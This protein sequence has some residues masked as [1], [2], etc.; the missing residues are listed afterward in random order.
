MRPSF[1][2]SD[3]YP[4]GL[5]RDASWPALQGV[6]RWLVALPYP[7]GGAHTNP[8]ATGMADKRVALVNNKRVLKKKAAEGKKPADD[9]DGKKPV[10]DEDERK[11]GDEADDDDDVFAVGT[12]FVGGDGLV[13]TGAASSA[14]GAIVPV[15]A[16]APEASALAVIAVEAPVHME[17]A[18]RAGGV[19]AEAAAGGAATELGAEDA[20]GMVQLGT[21]AGL[22]KGLLEQKTT[23]DR[24]HLAEVSRDL[25]GHM[26]QRVTQLSREVGGKIDGLTHVVSAQGA[27]IDAHDERFEKLEQAVA[28]LREQVKDARGQGT[29]EFS[30]SFV[31][32]EGWCKFEDRAAGGV[33]REEVETHVTA[34]KDKAPAGIRGIMGEIHVGGYRNSRFRI[35][36]AHG[37][38]PEVRDWMRELYERDTT[39]RIN[40]A[41]MRVKVERSPAQKANLARF[42]RGLRAAEQRLEVLRVTPAEGEAD[43]DMGEMPQRRRRTGGYGPSWWGMS[44]WP[45]FR[46]RPKRWCGRWRDWRACRWPLGRS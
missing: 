2:R 12:G 45:T 1:T 18:G 20:G 30:P 4:P 10:D 33:T 21:V 14:A 44:L 16:P 3:P 36:V 37:R 9:D 43:I 32:V 7:P 42:L 6:G 35:M 17:G 11:V 25:R 27:R 19:G 23:E 5:L 24:A 29:A 8:R 28:E 39:M 38:A 26:D 46:G 31:E 13:P 40:G 34:L 41:G 22:L 15:A